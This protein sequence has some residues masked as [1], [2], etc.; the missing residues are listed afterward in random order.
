MSIINVLKLISNYVLNIFDAIY[1]ILYCGTMLNKR[2]KNANINNCTN[3]ESCRYLI[4]KKIFSTVNFL[5]HSM[6]LDVGCGQGRILGYLYNNFPSLCITGIEIN[7]DAYLICKRWVKKKNIRLFFGDVFNFDLS[8][9][10]IFFLGHP[11]YREQFRL[12]IDQIE[13][14]VKQNSLLI[15][16][17]DSHYKDIL[18][19][20]YKWEMMGREKISRYKGL[21]LLN[22]PNYFSVWCYSPNKTNV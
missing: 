4:I 1:D 2:I 7:K 16:V 14:Q 9:Y 5:G 3:S 20:N 8:E 11:F 17:I 21:F 10:S 18:D 22:N 19:N 13:R 15:C 12:F 6:F